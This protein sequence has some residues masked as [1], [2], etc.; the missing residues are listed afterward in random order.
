[1]KLT[2]LI[3]EVWKDER[4]REMRL[5]KDEVKVFIEVLAD[6]IVEGL[7]KHGKV[8][9]K[10]LFTLELRK[11]KGRKI[12]NPRTKEPMYINDY[13]KVGIE[14]SKRLKDELKKLK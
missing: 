11:A 6:H 14:T 5:R 3:H 8:K 1:M 2:E 12:A 13:Y 10:N 7:L 4:V 9:I